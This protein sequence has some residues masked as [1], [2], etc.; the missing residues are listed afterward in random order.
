MTEEYVSIPLDIPGTKVN[1][2]NVSA[3]GEIHISV[4]STVEGTHCHQCRK[5]IR[6]LYDYGREVKLRHLSI[7]GKPTYLLIR[8]RRY[9]CPFCHDKPTTTQELE[10]YDQRS[11]STKAYENHI[12]KQLVNSTVYDVSQKD[13]VGY[14]TVEDIID[15]QI[16]KSV[17]WNDFHNLPT[18]GIDEIAIKKGHRDFVTIVTVRYE[19][20][21][22]RVLGV[23]ENREKVTVK[24]FFLSIP[25]HLRDTVESLCT[26]LYEGYTESAREVF[27]DQVVITADRFHI[28]K[29]YREPVD[30]ARKDEMRR[31]QEEL[32]KEEYE[33][34]T[35]A[36]WL[37]RKKFEDLDEEEQLVLNKL[38]RYSP[39]LFSVYIYA[40][41]LTAIFEQPYTKQ[42][43]EGML[44]A[45]MSIVK[46]AEIGYFD[47]FLK[48]IEEKMDLITNYFVRRKSSGFVEGLNHKIKVMLRRCYGMLN[49]IHIF[50][51][52]TLDLNGYG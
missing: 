30:D 2:V 18:I 44:R 49:R 8:P 42:E 37:V 21:E 5:E 51:R 14:D 17:D 11:S 52:L 19:S 9:I 35:G 25:K 31:L 1:G 46:E 41:A 39:L 16:G 15:R 40:N 13:D 23:L 33:E 12:I 43:A 32:P 38:F 3:E 45:W 20:G 48:T 22:I 24:E 50:Q 10:W 28:A 26:D 4:T 6:N 47:K 34:F 27:G 29:L 7:L 36:L